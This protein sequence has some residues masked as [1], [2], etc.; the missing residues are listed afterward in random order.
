MKRSTLPIL[1]LVV[2]A[3]VGSCRSPKGNSAVGDTA[4]AHTRAGSLEGATKS[5][6]AS[7]MAGMPGMA[8]AA[9]SMMD[10]VR[11]HMRMMQSATPEQMKS[12]L[13]SHRQTVA[14]M[15]SQMNAEMR[16]MNMAADAEWNATV[17]SIRQDLIHMPEMSGQELK[18]MVP[19]HGARV[20]RLLDVHERMLSNGR[21]Q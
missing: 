12:M 10:S 14:N 17:D 9:S 19:A 21:K 5:D 15:L 6:S 13:P 2:T 4:A 8:N 16:S 20:M 1:G 7:G 18:A 11:T 3:T